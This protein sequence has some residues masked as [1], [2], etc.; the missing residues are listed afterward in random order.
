MKKTN[1]N[2]TVIRLADGRTVTMPSEKNTSLPMVST[3]NLI[4]GL[5]LSTSVFA[6]IMIAI[7]MH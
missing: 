5:M 1:T 6:M 3:R 7:A 2:M 4:A